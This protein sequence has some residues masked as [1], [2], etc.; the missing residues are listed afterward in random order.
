M[1]DD[2]KT[3]PGPEQLQHL[4]KQY[5]DLWEQQ[6]K[7]LSSDETLARTMAQTMEL[8]NA[9]AA[10]VAAML[11]KAATEGNA[12]HAAEGNAAQN[13]MGGGDGSSNSTGNDAGNATGKR[14]DGRRA[15]SA[16]AASGDTEPDVRKLTDRIAELE[17]RLAQLEGA[18]QPTGKSAP[19][20][21]RKR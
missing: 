16:G 1:N 20:K 11:K 14:E 13:G 9:G 4:A 3:D 2:E 5:V 19:R 7:A 10:S 15:A 6:I 12:A 8:M 21:P 17:R 18:A